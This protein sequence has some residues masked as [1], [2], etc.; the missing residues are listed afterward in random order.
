MKAKIGASLKW[1][2][3]AQVGS[4]Q[5]RPEVGFVQMA[6]SQ[7]YASPNLTTTSTSRKV[8]IFLEKND[9]ISDVICPYYWLYK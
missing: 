2:F 6:V 8:R 4:R 9:V 7:E 1:H 5:N 3:G